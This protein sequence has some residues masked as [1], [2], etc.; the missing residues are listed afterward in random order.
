MYE[1]GWGKKLKWIIAFGKNSCVDVTKRYTQNISEIIEQ[2]NQE[3]EEVWIQNLI[4][5][6]NNQW[7]SNENDNK[8]L[9]LKRIE[10]DNHSMNNKN[11][12]LEE[13]R[14]R[15]SGVI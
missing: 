5:F 15:L 3:I 6:R 12:K 14:E 13:K 4:N 10:I 1:I 9:Y 11:I 2:R 7:L 8:E